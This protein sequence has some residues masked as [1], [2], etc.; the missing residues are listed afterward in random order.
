MKVSYKPILPKTGLTFKAEPQDKQ[1]SASGDAPQ[2]NTTQ[3]SS[4]TFSDLVNGAA[5]V[6]ER[7]GKAVENTRKAVEE[8]KARVAD[9]EFVKEATKVAAKTGEV[10]GDVSNKAQQAA[11]KAKTVKQHPGAVVA[12]VTRRATKIPGTDFSVIDPNRALVS[13]YLKR[14]GVDTDIAAMPTKALQRCANI[15]VD[16][17][18]QY[19]GLSLVE[20]GRGFERARQLE[21]AA[22][23]KSQLDRALNNGSFELN[24]LVRQTPTDNTPYCGDRLLTT[25]VQVGNIADYEASQMTEETIKNNLGSIAEQLQVGMSQK[26][27]NDFTRA[28]L[29]VKVK[30]PEAFEGAWSSTDLDNRKNL[31]DF[32]E[33]YG[34]ELKDQILK[35]LG[36]SPANIAEYAAT[37]RLQDRLN[38]LVDAAY[39]GD[40]DKLKEWETQNFVQ[41]EDGTVV[42]GM[43]DPTQFNIGFWGE[44]G[45]AY[46]PKNVD[47]YM[48]TKYVDFLGRKGFDVDKLDEVDRYISKEQRKQARARMEEAQKQ[49]K[50][51]Q[52]VQAAS[53]FKARPVDLNK[54]PVMHFNLGTPA[55][56]VRTVTPP[57]LALCGTEFIPVPENFKPH[58]SNTAEDNLDDL[59]APEETS[60]NKYEMMGQSLINTPIIPQLPSSK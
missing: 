40:T 59:F 35:D 14:A 47:N 54:T 29:G 15:K 53:Q 26:F 50:L 21:N 12:D 13:Q 31:T 33:I 23:I 56:R 42:L 36:G 51:Q 45:N 28:V 46:I 27:Q 9:S 48:E 2:D 41:T 19:M 6:I 49:A 22:I 30:Q 18:Y 24:A 55:P 7:A 17:K 52:A 57:R 16:P 8:T 20:D 32:V 5:Q 58:F 3:K 39:S 11:E 38:S 10:I 43:I 34:N 25:I 44:V 4:F 1:Y 60:P 37:K